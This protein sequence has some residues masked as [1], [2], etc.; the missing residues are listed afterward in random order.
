MIDEV[1][2]AIHLQWEDVPEME[3]GCYAY[4]AEHGDIELATAAQQRI[5][6]MGR[7]RKCG[8][9]LNEFNTADG[10]EFACPKCDLPEVN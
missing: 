7:C 3:Y 6:K 4:F 10:L 5:D 8:T 1:L 9:L 2:N